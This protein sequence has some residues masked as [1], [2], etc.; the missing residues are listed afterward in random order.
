MVI[1]AAFAALLRVCTNEDFL[2]VTAAV[3]A[4]DKAVKVCVDSGSTLNATLTPDA[5]RRTKVMRRMPS[6]STRVMFTLLTLTPTWPVKVMMATLQLCNPNPN[7]IGL[8][9]LTV[10]QVGPL[11]PLF[12][13]TQG[14]SQCQ[15][16]SH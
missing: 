11:V 13:K 7:P 1:F 8:L 6:M 9:T 5:T 15:T 10:T 2:L 14:D 16:R 12:G 3:I 4:L